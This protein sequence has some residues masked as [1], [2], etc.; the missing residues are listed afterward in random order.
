MSRRLN[1][2][3]KSNEE[4]PIVKPGNQGPDDTT[5]RDNNEATVEPDSPIDSEEMVNGERLEDNEL[6]LPF[7]PIPEWI[8][9]IQTEIEVRFE[10][11]VVWLVQKQFPLEPEFAFM[12]VPVCRI[13]QECAAHLDPN[14]KVVLVLDSPGGYAGV[15]YQIAT[16]LRDNTKEFNVIVPRYAKSAATLLAVGAS[17]IFM[18]RHAELGPLDAQITDPDREG[19][20]SA[21]DEVQALERLHASALE[22]LDR[23]MFLL[24][25]RMGKRLDKILPHACCFVAEL[26]KPLFEKIDAVHFT[27]MSRA[28]K[29]AEAYA[30]R[31]LAPNYQNAKV[32]DIANKLITGYPEH[33]FVIDKNE[34][35]T[36]L[37][38]RIEDLDDQ[39]TNK[40][41]RIIDEYPFPILGTITKME[42][43]K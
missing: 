42:K 38:L 3:P 41:C 35:K 18:G 26:M 24:V 19:T 8:I 43:P 16:A 2:V 29:V 20:M 28:L 34:A 9:D 27:Q 17:Q 14:K 11:Q 23:T 15:A 30:V 6:R 4:S 22:A 12:G 13:L 1:T 39:L 25:P 32:E 10:S 37:G 33:G 31:L 21:L 36:V 40:I 7:P 5:P